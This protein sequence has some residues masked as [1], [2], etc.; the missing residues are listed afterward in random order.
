MK[1]SPSRAMYQ[2]SHPTAGATRPGTLN[3]DQV[4][5]ASVICWCRQGW[6]PGQPVSECAEYVG[7]PACCSRASSPEASVIAVPA[8]PAM[9]SASHGTQSLAAVGKGTF[10]VMARPAFT[11][12]L[13][14]SSSRRSTAP[15]C[16]KSDWVTLPNPGR[17]TAGRGRA[18][19]RQPARPPEDG[20]LRELR[21]VLPG[22]RV[23]RQRRASQTVRSV[24]M[25]RSSRPASPATTLS[26]APRSA[27][28][29]RPSSPCRI[30]PRVTSA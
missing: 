4:V 24:R 15:H 26:R 23:A 20:E 18:R 11:I 13:R 3:I 1:K 14:R 25:L 7:S 6:K 30:R 19:R 29:I 16:R 10:V 17:R 28:D 5:T 21:V 8:T 12:S 9:M 27:G 2:C 22:A